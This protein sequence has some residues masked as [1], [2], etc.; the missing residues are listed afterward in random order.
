MAV[1]CTVICLVGIIQVT[2]YYYPAM[3]TPHNYSVS[4]CDH[5]DVLDNDLALH[6]T[7]LDK[8][9]QCNMKYLLASNTQTE[10]HVQ[11][12]KVGLC[13]QTLFSGLPYQPQ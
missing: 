6:H 4:G 1:A 2:A 8:K 9:Y 7:H 10:F 13:K 11:R 12:L 5:P 3:H